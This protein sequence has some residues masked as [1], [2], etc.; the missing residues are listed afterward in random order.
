ME[1]KRFAAVYSNEQAADLTEEYTELIFKCKCCYGDPQPLKEK[2]S[3]L[4]PF[5]AFF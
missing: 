3:F 5:A 1:V 4:P 2:K